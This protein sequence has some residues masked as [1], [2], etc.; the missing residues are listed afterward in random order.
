MNR[1]F[2]FWMQF[3]RQP[4]TDDITLDDFERLWM[5]GKGGYGE[6]HLV[7]QIRGLNVGKYYAMKIMEMNDI[8]RSTVIIRH[9]QTE[10][11]VSAEVGDSPFLV[12]S[13]YTFVTKSHL[14]LV[15]DFMEG[16]DLCELLDK[17]RK[18]RERELR[19]FEPVW[20]S[21]GPVPGFCV[22]MGFIYRDLK[23][24]NILIDSIGHL[25]ITDYGLCRKL[26]PPQK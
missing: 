9:T 14:H 11:I 12:K 7:K 18:L 19:Q 6:V 24:E 23:P 13:H 2:P 15:M 10:C 17:E 1:N 25:R 5:I 20:P 22:I 3:D 8:T 26:C 16:G 4:Q 21:S